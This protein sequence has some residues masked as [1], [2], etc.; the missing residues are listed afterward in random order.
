MS[1]TSIDFCFARA[2]AALRPPKS[3]PTMI[4]L[5][6]MPSKLAAISCIVSI[7]K[8]ATLNEGLDFNGISLFFSFVAPNA[9]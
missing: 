1:V 9:R 5:C 6:D 8:T 4:N 2:L 7:T 3:A